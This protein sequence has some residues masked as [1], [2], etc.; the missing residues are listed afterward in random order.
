VDHVAIEGPVLLLIGPIGT[1]FARLADHFEH[2][3]VAVTKISFPLH[4][5]GFKSHQRVSYSDSMEAFPSF[6]RSLILERGIR[7][8]FM[9]GDFI[10]PHRLA[11]EVVQQLNRETLLPYRLDAWVFELGYV[12]PNYVSLELERVNAR[13]N[14]NKPVGF[15]AS[16]PE[17]EAIPAAPRD[18]GFRWRKAW[19]M[20][21]FIQHAF[22]AYPIINGPHKLQPKPSYLLAQIHGLLRKHFYRLTELPIHRRLQDGTP[23]VLVPLQV[24][25]DSQVSLGSD[26]AGMEPFIA[27]IIASFADHAPASDRLAF[28]HHPRDRGYNHY[29]ALIESLA[30][31]HRVSERVLYFHDGALGP[32]LKR[33]KAVL[34]INSTVGLQALYHGV[35]TKVMGRTFYNMPGLTDQQDLADFWREPRSSDRGLY[36]K[37]YRYMIETTQVNGNFDGRF[38]FDSVFSI[39]PSLAIHA[40]GPRPGLAVLAVRLLALLKGFLLYYIQLLALVVGARQAAWR[41]LEQGARDCLSGMGVRVLMERRSVPLNRAHDRAQIHIA[42]HGH[43]LDVL[44]VQGYFCTCSMTTAAKHLRWLFPFF[45]TS[46]RHYGHVNL[47]HLCQRSRLEG[48]RQLLAV[49]ETRGRLFLFPSGS[50][51]TPITARVSGSLSVI[52]RRSGA[53]IIPWFITY[54]GFP[55]AEQACRYKPLALIGRRLFGPPATI[56]C[57][58]GAAIDP[59]DFPSQHALS[60]HIRELYAS[61]QA[62]M[63]SIPGI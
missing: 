24:S 59:R 30:R 10:D 56:L 41:L 6:L 44:L 9:Y 4:E 38:P 1:F 16:L 19:K 54:R 20:P 27:D 22:T 29:G 62:A 12:R 7:H 14:L 36:R 40:T 46:A 57:Q 42:N 55:R 11:I 37:F 45:A 8:I 18:P 31:R 23:Y 51:I 34:T 15:Y 26:Y 32:I 25:S 63:E 2:R 3:G 13:S 53:L 21:T 50:L 52:S 43:P 17:V 60:A 49:M 47:D 61:N 33:A 39:A 28:K 58:Q 35:P 48:L 5:F